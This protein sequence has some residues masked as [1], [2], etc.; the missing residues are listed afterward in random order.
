MTYLTTFSDFY[1]SLA[2]KMIVQPLVASTLTVSLPIPA[3][4]PVITTTRSLKSRLARQTPPLKYSR[5]TVMKAK[6][7][8][9]T[10]NALLFVR[11]SL[12]FLTMVSIK[13]NK[14][15]KYIQKISL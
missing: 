9:A 1:L 11:I 4:P 15:Q 7:P 14:Y 8:A 13:D 2:P 6:V 10:A 12:A 3:L 5:A